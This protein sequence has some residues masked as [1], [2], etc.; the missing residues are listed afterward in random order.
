MSGLLK[1]FDVFEKTLGANAAA[2]GVNLLEEVAEALEVLKNVSKEVVEV[3]DQ[4]KADAEA[5]AEAE[6]QAKA[7]AEEAADAEF[8][9]YLDDNNFVAFVGKGGKIAKLLD[10]KRVKKQARLLG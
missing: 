5:K 4:A 3:L 6:A 10:A 1:T 7:D 9:K 8:V 2:A